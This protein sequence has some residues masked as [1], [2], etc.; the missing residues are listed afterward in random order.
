MNEYVQSVLSRYIKEKGFTSD[1]VFHPQLNLT[2]LK[3]HSD[4]PWLWSILDK[5]RNFEWSWVENFKNNDWNWM[6]ISHHP[7]FKWNWVKTF[8]DAQWDWVYLSTKM[9]LNEIL[10]FS[11]KPLDWAYLTMS[12]KVSVNFMTENFHFPWTARDLFFTDIG[13][14]EIDYL[15]QFRHVYNDI[16]WDDHTRHAS[17]DFIKEN[18]DLPWEKSKIR[19]QPYE[20]GDIEIIKSNPGN[21]NMRT[22]SMDIPVHVIFEN[23]HMNWDYKFGVSLNKTL[24]FDYV[25]NNPHIDWNSSFVPIDL[26]IDKWFAANTIKRYWKHIVTN[27]EYA[28]CRRVFLRKMDEIK[29][30]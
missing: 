14:D 20:E 2:V 27:P 19:I 11:N 4:S 13:P 15:R 23:T 9:D 17:W 12:P 7:K 18:M 6:S 29:I 1:L 25:K 28:T 10:L 16:D 26:E 8:P 5:H 3:K 21:W 24:T 30:R 22:L